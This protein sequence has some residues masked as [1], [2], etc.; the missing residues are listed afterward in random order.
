MPVTPLGNVAESVV[1]FGGFG[2]MV[3]VADYVAHSFS[4]DL[5]PCREK[6][7]ELS[8]EQAP[9]TFLLASRVSAFVHKRLLA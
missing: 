2:G 6:M 9:Q 8:A 3:V 4:R 1:F 5:K 7:V